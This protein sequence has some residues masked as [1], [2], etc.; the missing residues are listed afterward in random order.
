[1]AEAPVRVGPSLVTLVVHGFRCRVPRLCLLAVLFFLAGGEFFLVPGVV[2][3]RG[4]GEAAVIDDDLLG[5]RLEVSAAEIGRSGLQ[6][7]KE[8]CGGPV[9]H[10]VGEEKTQALHEG[11][12]DGVSVFEDGQ[13]E[14]VTGTA[15]A[16]GVELDAMLLPLLVKV[17]ELTLLECRGNRT[18]S[19]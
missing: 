1:V 10:L 12:L 5:L 6:G 3:E 19:R 7:I 4:I 2:A 13:V 18:G 9:V 11:D 17:T 14:R 16:V 15:G 8:E